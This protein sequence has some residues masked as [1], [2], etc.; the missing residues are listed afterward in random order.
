MNAVYR[1]TSTLAVF[2]LIFGILCWFA[3]PFVGAI[4]AVICGHAARGEIRRAPI[5]TIDG[6]GMALAGVILGW[7]HLALFVIIIAFVFLVLG[8]FAFFGHWFH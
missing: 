8:G 6:D 2:S 4:I 5:G 1:H 7:V 3:L